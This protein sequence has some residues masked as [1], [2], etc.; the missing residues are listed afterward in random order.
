MIPIKSLLK[1]RHIANFIGFLLIL[2]T[3]AVAGIGYTTYSNLSSIVSGLEKD[4]HPNNNLILYK[5]IMVYLSTMENKVESYQLS[6]DATYLE[7]YDESVVKVFTYLDSLDSRNPNDEE[8]L[9]LNDSL[10]NLINHKTNILNQILQLSVD[11]DRSELDRLSDQIDDISDI[12]VP[13]S[14]KELDTIIAEIDQEE[15]VAQNQEEENPTTDERGFLKKLFKKKTPVHIT[16]EPEESSDPPKVIVKS[17]GINKDS[18]YLAQTSQY[19]A[20]LQAAL[21]QIQESTI[22][23]RRSLKEKESQL[24]S[25][26]AQVQEEIMQLIANLEKRESVKLK[27]NSLK[28]QELASRTN[29]QIL[30]FSS[31]AFLLLLVTISVLFSYVQKNKE[32]QSLLQ[33][34]KKSAEVLAK[35]KERFFAN[36]SHEI[37][38]P[39]NAI[40]GFSKILMKSKLDPDQKEQVEIINKSS[41]HLLKLLNDILDFSKLQAHK[42]QLETRTFDL[43][44]LCAETCKLLKEPAKEKNL[45]LIE[46][47]DELPKYVTGDPYRLK[48]I[49]LN[50]LN[51]SIKYTEKGYVELRVKGKPGK[52]KSRVTFEIIDTGKGIS[53]DHQHKLFQEFE[54][55]DQSS[56]SKGTGLGLAITKRLVLLHDGDISLNSK[57]GDGTVVKVQISYQLSD[58][59]PDSTQSYTYHDGLKGTKALVADDEPF[60]VKLLTT[61]LDKHQI[62]YDTAT[63]G[64]EAYDLLLKE[65]YDVVLLD[66]KMPEMTGWE[67][68]KSIK[69]SDNPNKE[70]PFI[71][72]TATVA[73]LDRSKIEMSGFS[74]ILRKPFDEA[75]LFGL[76]SNHAGAQI[77]AAVAVSPT[78]QVDSIDLSTLEQ[79]GD[80]DFVNDMVETFIKSAEEGWKEIEDHLKSGQLAV[81]SNAAHRIVAPA[82]HLKA[83]KLVEL[84]K[85]IEL[86]ADQEKPIPTELV[87]E[88]KSHLTNTIS[89][90]QSYL[91]EEKAI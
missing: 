8:L 30:I 55:S 89:Q 38:T 45:E 12:K 20:K 24:Q 28:A 78:A 46:T 67:V 75:E 22:E 86:N 29:Q 19:R 74:H 47:Y 56:F 66:L 59:I 15:L 65:T 50:L 4:S 21:E 83:T 11:S 40:S 9:R 41:D 80:R 16:N 14:L 70:K 82:R 63:N 84:L 51:N 17:K 26:H 64:K 48:Q 85:K 72:L 91:E 31:L 73:K 13:D 81:V 43:H 57:E 61:L 76:I 58:T 54:Q 18:I 42:L 27:I 68:V 52:N 77:N 37:R 44:E 7:K 32:Y 23:Q 25:S 1:R 49:L 34:S 33:G 10:A 79:M 69:E 71:A 62:I 36:M 39:M 87:S 6:N 2:L 3:I 5:A 90:L 35:A 53:K 60:N 88:T